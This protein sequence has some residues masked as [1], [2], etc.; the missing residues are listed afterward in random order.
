MKQVHFIVQGKGGV[1][2]SLIASMLAQY[3]RQYSNKRVFC[4]DTDPVNPTF[5]RYQALNVEIINISDKQHNIIKREFDTLVDKL[6]DNGDNIAV[7]DSGAGTYKPLM[8]YFCENNLIELLQQQQGMEIFFHIPLYGADALEDTLR[9]LSAMLEQLPTAK[10]VV[11]INHDKNQIE[12]GGGRNF[13]QLEI[14]QKN[15]DRIVGVVELIKRDDSTYRFDIAEM[16]TRHLTIDE[17]KANDFDTAK[18]EKKWKWVEMGRVI[19]FYQAI[20]DQLKDIPL[21]AA[22]AAKSAKVDKADKIE[23]STAAA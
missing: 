3:L 15:A 9:N 19:Q 10:V 7:V 14:Y 1:G 6:L 8:A 11:W 18:G 2:K 4:F 22:P 12:F 20:C 17:I 5:S 23:K 21:F 16:A 13:N